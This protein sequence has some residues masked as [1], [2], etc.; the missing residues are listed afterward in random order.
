MNNPKTIISLCDYSGT[1]SRPYDE[2]GYRV[3]QVD[4]KLDPE[5][6]CG[7]CGYRPLPEGV[8]IYGCP[9]CEGD[10]EA[11]DWDNTTRLALTVQEVLAMV[12]QIDPVYGILMAP[13]CTHF[14]L[15][16]A[17]YWR[18]KD[19]DGR[20]AEGLAIV[21][22][23][24]SL[25]EV[26]R[27][28]WWVL[29]NPVGRLPQL[30]PNTLGQPRMYFDPCDYGDPYTK[31][32]GLWGRFT[33]PLPL[34]IGGDWRVEPVE[35]SKMLRYGGNSERTKEQRSETPEGFAQAFFM[36]NP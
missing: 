18:Q 9:N 27:P 31:K 11:E 3:F 15:S 21:D 23:C 34:F 26:V 17:Q 13:P 30:R 36:A 4:I 32:T 28:R 5:N 8:G 12:D 24:L 29:E 14:S 20:T 16:G 33:P 35:G 10:L 2:A 7:F 1:W 6:V 25:V 19:K 22:A